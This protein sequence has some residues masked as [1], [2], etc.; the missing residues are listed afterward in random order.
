M[1]YQLTGC[2]DTGCILQMC[3][4]HMCYTVLEG[5]IEWKSSPGRLLVMLHPIKWKTCLIDTADKQRRQKP[6]FCLSMYLQG[7]QYRLKYQW[8]LV[9]W[10][11]SQLHMNS[12][13]K[14]LGGKNTDQANMKCTL[15]FL[16][17]YCMSQKNIYHM[18]QSLVIQEQ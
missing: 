18:W 7:M 15:I 1:L 14:A 8:H 3:H 11:I 4:C 6:H 2:F 17:R 12:I 5:Y 10:S 9:L 13:L 16:C